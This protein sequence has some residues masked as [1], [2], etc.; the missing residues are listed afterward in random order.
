VSEEPLIA[1]L[2]DDES[3]RTAL[4]ESLDSV[5]YVA[6][7]FGS[8]E[9]FIEGMRKDRATASSPTFKCQA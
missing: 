1:V 9:E 6:R 3:F 5:G 7:G 8:A 2:D 4:V